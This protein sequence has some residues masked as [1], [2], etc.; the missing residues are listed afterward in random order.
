MDQKSLFLEKIYKIPFFDCWPWSVAFFRASYG[1]EKKY[2]TYKSQLAHRYA[3][4]LFVG[5]IPKNMYVC[6]KC[7]NTWCVNPDHLFLGTQKD[8]MMDM[9]KKNRGQKTGGRKKQRIDVF[10]NIEN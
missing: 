5:E 3:Y 9:A 8:N 1:N 2:G 10:L 4:K 6:H 7:D